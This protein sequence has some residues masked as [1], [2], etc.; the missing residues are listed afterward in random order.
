MHSSRALPVESGPVG[1]KNASS[2]GLFARLGHDQLSGEQCQRS[3]C[4]MY[5]DKFANSM[6]QILHRYSLPDFWELEESENVSFW[7]ANNA[8]LSQ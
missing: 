7:R 8:A 5:V 6:S 1:Q 3:V 4:P 2:G